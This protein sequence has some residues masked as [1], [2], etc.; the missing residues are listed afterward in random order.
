MPA[1]IS[2]V[3]IQEWVSRGERLHLLQAGA[4]VAELRPFDGG[5]WIWIMRGQTTPGVHGQRFA[6]LCAAQA[7]LS[8]HFE[9]HVVSRMSPAARDALRAAGLIS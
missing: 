2:R 5:G 1:M 7:E 6:D 8:A 4:E 9:S 3:V